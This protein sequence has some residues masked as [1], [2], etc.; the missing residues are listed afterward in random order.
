MLPLV[1]NLLPW[2]CDSFEFT[3]YFFLGFPASTST[4]ACVSL[5]SWSSNG[6]D[7]QAFDINLE[8]VNPKC[9]WRQPPLDLTQDSHTQHKVL[10]LNVAKVFPFILKAK[11]K[12]L[13]VKPSLGWV[14]KFYRKTICT[15]FDWSSQ[16]DLH[17]KSCRTLDS[18]FTYKHILSK[19]KIRLK[20][21]DHGL[22]TLEIE[23]LIHLNLKS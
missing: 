12:T 22:S 5:S 20:H 9:M 19:S 2:P 3:D 11:H 10:P 1:G 23:V 7:H 6:I 15:I 13:H 21:F 16:L 14:G 4:P 18:N 8:I 17:S